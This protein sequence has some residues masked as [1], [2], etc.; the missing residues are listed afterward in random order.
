MIIHTFICDDCQVEVKDTNTKIIHHCPECQK[1]MRWKLDG[2]G[3][4]QGDYHHVSE[5]LAIHPDLATEHRKNFPD[6]DVLPDGCLEFHSVRSQER[7]AN[8][9]GFEKKAQRIRRKGIKVR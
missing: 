9:C 4:A 2:I 1:E 8:R 5:S 6:V 7:Y 3:I